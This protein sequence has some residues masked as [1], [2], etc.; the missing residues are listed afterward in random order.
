MVGKVN[1]DLNHIYFECECGSW[2][3]KNYFPDKEN[4]QGSGESYWRKEALHWKKEAQRLKT[5]RDEILRMYNKLSREIT[6]AY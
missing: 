6:E 4:A 3:Y 2:G 1:K 5:E